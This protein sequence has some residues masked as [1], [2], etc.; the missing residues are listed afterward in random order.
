MNLSY[1]TF[2]FS[3]LFMLLL[4]YSIYSIFVLN[5][6]I[7]PLL[8]EYFYGDK[9]GLN[10]AKNILEGTK[11]RSDDADDERNTKSDRIDQTSDR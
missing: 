6:K 11:R 8:E 7:E 1:K 10:E 2:T 9:E 5:Y 3:V 4:T